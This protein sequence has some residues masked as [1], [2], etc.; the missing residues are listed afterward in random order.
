MVMERADFDLFYMLKQYQTS[1]G[2]LRGQCVALVRSITWQ[3][4][5]VME[6]LHKNWV[7]HRDIK[8]SNVLLF[9]NGVRCC[10]SGGGGRVGCGGAGGGSTR[11]SVV[12]LQPNLTQTQLDRTR[13]RRR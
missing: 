8:P 10:G 6:F 9:A 4:T 11:E 1:H 2:Q 13:S 3:L 5:R 7:L 12:P